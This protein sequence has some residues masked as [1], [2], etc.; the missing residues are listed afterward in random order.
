MDGTMAKT[1]ID[2]FDELSAAI[3]AFL[4]DRFPAREYVS[5]EIAGLSVPEYGPYDPETGGNKII[6]GEIDPETPFF[7]STLS[8]LAEAE[9]LS[10]K[11][12]RH[13]SNTYTLTASTMKCLRR[14]S[15]GDGGE[16]FGVM[17]SESVRNGDKEAAAAILNQALTT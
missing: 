7:G 1:N 17:L 4:Y 9:V 8:W 5:P 16:T 3:V 2:R 6:S 13:F 15:Q 14:Y 11:D 10:A 12:N